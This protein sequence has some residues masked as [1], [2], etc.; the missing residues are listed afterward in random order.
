M[1]IVFLLGVSSQGQNVDCAD[2]VQAP[3]GLEGSWN[4]YQA[5][6]ETSKW[7]EAYASALAADF[8]GV[9]GTLASIHTAVENRFVHGLVGTDQHV[10]IGLSDRVGVAPNAQEGEFAWVSGEPLTFVNWRRGQPNNSGNSEDAIYLFRNDSDWSDDESGFAS[11]Q[12]MPDSESRDETRG[13][14]YASVIEFNTNSPL[15][16]PGIKAFHSLLPRTPLEGQSG[17]SGNWGVIDY[18]GG[19]DLEGPIQDVLDALIGIQAGTKAAESIAAQLPTLTV[20]DPEQ[21]GAKSPQLGLDFG[22]GLFPYPSDNLTGAVDDDDMITVAHGQLR[23]QEDG[24]YTFQVQSSEGFAMRVRGAPVR[25]VA[26]TGNVDPYD[27]ETFFHAGNTENSNV[28]AT[29]EMKADEVYDVEFVTWEREGAAFY[30]VAVQIGDVINDPKL[31]PQWI[32]LGDATHVPL[33]EQLP[34]ARLTDPLRVVNMNRIDEFDQEIEFAREIILSNLDNPD[35]ESND[36]TRFQFDDSNRD[37]AG[38]PFGDFNHDGEA[39]QWPNTSGNRD[40]FASGIFGALQVDDGDEVPN[41]SIEVSFYVASDDRSSFRIIGQS[42]ADVSNEFLLELDGDDAIASDQNGCQNSYTGVITLKEGVDYSFEGIHVEKGGDA[43][44]QVLAAIGDHVE[45]FQPAAFS[46][47]QMD[48]IRLS[49]NVGL[50]LVGDGNSLIGD[51]NQNGE[52]DAEDLDLQAAA[53]A[54]NDLQYDLNDDSTVDLDDRIL[55]VRDL[56]NTWMGDANLDGEFNSS[57][58]VSVFTAGRFETGQTA[59]WSHGDWNGDGL[60][61]TSDFVVAFQGQGFEAGPRANAEIVPEPA[62]SVVG[63]LGLIWLV[64]GCAERRKRAGD[65]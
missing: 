27:S 47:L 49:P 19:L 58:F 64:F 43:G 42:F 24:V 11:G 20:A 35:A 38:C 15:P 60:F 13:K 21:P 9:P 54:V 7:S 26:G 16:Y 63:V 44:M 34:T 57:D 17:S 1:V 40:N 6:Y 65:N 23:P 14:R 25:D 33:V 30:E 4:V 59:S 48:P 46:L 52:L 62:S 39:P 56:A 10:W 29:Y 51:Y 36:V 12:P 45:S 50:A 31:N 22:A 28:R 55:W 8:D 2:P 53:I 32:A 3:F 37:P 18:Y 41:E 5:C 61:T